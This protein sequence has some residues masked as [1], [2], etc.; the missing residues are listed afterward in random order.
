MATIL[1]ELASTFAAYGIKTVAP[2]DKNK[3]AY[4]L[5]DAQ[6]HVLT[7]AGI[8]PS[9]TSTIPV[10]VIGSN[11]ILDSSYYHSERAGSGRRP[12]PRMGRDLVN[13]VDVGDDLLLAT[14]GKTIFAKKLV[15]TDRIAQPPEEI[16]KAVETVYQQL[17]AKQLLERAKKAAVKPP[18]TPVTVDQ[19]V[20]DP[21]VKAL[22]I[23]RCGS[24]CEVPGC[25]WKG[26]E[27]ED[28]TFYIEVHHVKPLSDG[29]D[30]TVWNAAGVCSNCHSL[31]HYGTNRAEFAER[32]LKV[33]ET[34]Q[35]RFE[36]TL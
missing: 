10:R 16:E 9:R 14:D 1:D 11:L 36:A 12:E 23:R 31:A 25:G 28:G 32:L 35:L 4:V 29:G 3:A 7:R 8:G 24:T 22:V 30:D 33:V 19:F 13:W 20:R 15:P 21:A 5:T 2:T 27:K 26:F 6:V 18:R 34:A 17:D